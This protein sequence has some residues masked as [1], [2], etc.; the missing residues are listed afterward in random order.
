MSLLASKNNKEQLYCKARFSDG[1]PWDTSRL[2]G[3]SAKSDSN[4]CQSLEEIWV[5]MS[6]NKS[7]VQPSL[8]SFQRLPFELALL[9]IVISTTCIFISSELLPMILRR[10]EKAAEVEV[11]NTVFCT[12]LQAEEKSL[13]FWCYAR[14]QL[15]S[16]KSL[17]P[18]RTPL[19]SCWLCIPSAKGG[20]S[21]DK[22]ILSLNLFNPI[23]ILSQTPFSQIL[24]L[25]L[26]ALDFS[27]HF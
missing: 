9:G 6:H 2:Q 25:L 17:L 12:A 5:V 24:F 26:H 27:S 14:K 18:I 7:F 16:E 13:A 11:H 19:S 3:T 8:K 20:P 23:P 4:S 22:Q 1:S 21:R 10:S 15:S